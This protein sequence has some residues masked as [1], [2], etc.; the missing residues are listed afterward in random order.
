MIRVC[1]EN[2]DLELKAFLVLA[3]TPGMRKGEIPSRKWSDIDLDSGNPCAYTSGRRRMMS[4]SASSCRTWPLMLFERL[5]ATVET[6]TFFRR[7]RNH[8]SKAIFERPQWEFGKRFR[9]VAKYS[10][11]EMR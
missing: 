9:R 7:N 2:G 5:L 11:S 8:G 4:Q 10:Y 3:P 1:E 6:N